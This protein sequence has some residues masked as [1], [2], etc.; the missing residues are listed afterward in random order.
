VVRNG[1]VIRSGMAPTKGGPGSGSSSSIRRQQVAAC[2]L[3]DE[4][5]D[6]IICSSASATVQEIL[7]TP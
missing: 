2:I 4:W 5:A 7:E 6:G 1:A 3:L